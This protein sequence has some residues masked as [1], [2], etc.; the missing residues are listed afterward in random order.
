MRDSEAEKVAAVTFDDGIASAVEHGLPVLEELAAPGT[1][2]LTVTMLGWGGRIDDA[3]AVRLAERGWE[4]GSHTM[5]HPVLTNVDDA[6]MREELAESK[7]ALEQLTGRECAAIAYPTGKVDARV[8]TAAEA[9]GYVAGAALEGASTVPPGP[10]AWPRVGVRGDDSIRVFRLKCSRA[11]RGA[12][13]SWLRRPLS[14]RPSRL[15]A[16][17]RG[18]SAC[19]RRALRPSGGRSVGVRRRPSAPRAARA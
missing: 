12:R 6:L 18:A 14:G 15:P 16:G 2:F 3:G 17:P 8:V 9:A 13:A 7:Q 5:T 4:I 19:R 10:L 1:M 11:V